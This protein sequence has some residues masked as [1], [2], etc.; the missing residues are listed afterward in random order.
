MESR[1]ALL[2][3]GSHLDERVEPDMPMT[4]EDM[5]RRLGVAQVEALFDFIPVATLARRSRS[6][7]D[8]DGRAP[9]PGIRGAVDRRRVG[10][11]YSRLRARQPFAAISLSTV[12]IRARSMARLG[13]RLRRNQF[14]NGDR[15]RLGARGAHDW[16]PPRRRIPDA[17]GHALRGGCRGH[18]LRPLSAGVRPFLSFRDRSVHPSELLFLRLSIASRFALPRR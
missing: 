7:G 11:L 5:R 9:L 1:S 12:T 8:L 4:T 13:A 3:K 14:R 6:G 16:E 17:S 2:Y 18:R 10:L 15:F